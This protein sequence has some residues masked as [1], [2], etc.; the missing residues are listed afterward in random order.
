ME[1]CSISLRHPLRVVEYIYYEERANVF[2]LVCDNIFNKIVL[3]LFHFY[4][5]LRV[6]FC[7]SFCLPLSLFI[8]LCACAH[9]YW[10]PQK[11]EEGVRT[12]G[13][14]VTDSSEQSSVGAWNWIL[15]FCKS[16]KCHLGNLSSPFHGIFNKKNNLKLLRCHLIK[17][18][19][20]QA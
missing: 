3:D 10:C 11:P 1:F 6:S 4:L 16:S 19:G 8:C 15:F 7:L 14:G 12:H 2:V 5:C 17:Y 20:H 9:E 13:A 18:A